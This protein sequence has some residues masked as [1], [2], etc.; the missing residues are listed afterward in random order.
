MTVFYCRAGTLSVITNDRGGIVDDCI[1][2]RDG[3][4]SFYVVSNAACA[5]KVSMALKV[6][7]VMTTT[8]RYP[9][10]PSLPYFMV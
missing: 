3:P 2:S 6:C 8:T 1:I 4:K 7:A 10:T 5:D 9:V